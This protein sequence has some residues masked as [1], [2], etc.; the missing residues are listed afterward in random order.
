LGGLLKAAHAARVRVRAIDHVAA[1]QREAQ[2]LA[3]M[4]T[5]AESVV[6]GDAGRGQG[7]YLML[8]GHAHSTTRPGDEHSVKG[9]I[10]GS[11]PGLSQMLGIP[12]V[13]VEKR[14]PREPKVPRRKKR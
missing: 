12:A 10:T 5:H 11:V 6:R 8:V 13:E 7:K 1:H 2:R 4:N 14:I 9:G 3:T